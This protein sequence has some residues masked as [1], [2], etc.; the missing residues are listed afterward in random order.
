MTKDGNEIGFYENSKIYISDS[1]KNDT[2]ECIAI[3]KFNKRKCD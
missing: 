2:S 3:K 1:F